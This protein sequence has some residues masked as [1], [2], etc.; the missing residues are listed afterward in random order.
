LAHF[1]VALFGLLLNFKSPLYILDI[2]LYQM[3]FA[4]IFLWSELSF[5]SF[6]S[7]FCKQK[8]LILTRC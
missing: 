6:G 3:C 1:S 7:L 2:S 8:F 4:Y 5:H